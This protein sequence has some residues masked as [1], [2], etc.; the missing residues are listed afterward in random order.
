MADGARRAL[1]VMSVGFKNMI[2]IIIRGR[3]PIKAETTTLATENYNT[4]ADF[5]ENREASKTVKP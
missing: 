4:V 2:N 1:K 5:S 3:N